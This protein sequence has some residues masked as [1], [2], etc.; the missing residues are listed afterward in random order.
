LHDELL[1]EA[2]APMHQERQRLDARLCTWASNVREGQ[3][4]GV[5]EFRSI[6]YRR[7]RRLPTY[8]MIVQMFNHQTHHR[9]QLTTLLS[10]MGLDVGVTDM[11]FMP[12]ADTLCVDLPLEDG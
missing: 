12:F 9:G 8:L 7:K 3:L 11:P 5:Y 1:F 6:T 4:S 2:F 10:Q